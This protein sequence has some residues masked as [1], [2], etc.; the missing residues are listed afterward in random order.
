MTELELHFDEN[1]DNDKSDAESGQLTDESGEIADS[2]PELEK[3]NRRRERLGSTSPVRNRGFFEKEGGLS[4]DRNAS[5]G[6]GR[7]G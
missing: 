5:S 2:D 3:F 1:L 4:F 7:G 6:R